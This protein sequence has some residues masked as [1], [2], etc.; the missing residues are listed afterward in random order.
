VTNDGATILKQ[1]EVEH[2]AAKVLVELAELQ[3]S[4]VGDGTTSV[5]ILAAE[6]L[7][8]ANELVRNRIHPT[9]IMSGY[10]MAVKEAVK[11]IK[12]HLTVS[13]D[14]ME[15]EYLVNA[16]RTSMSSKILGSQNAELFAAMAVDAVTSVRKETPE[17]TKYPISNIHIIKSHGKSAAES[18]LV[19]GLALPQA[20]VSQQMPKTITG[21]KIALLDFN[22]Q[23]HR[24]QLGVQV[25]V[26]DPAQLEAIRQREADITKETIARICAAGAN[27]IFT[28]KAIDDLCQKYLVE[29][30]VLA[31]RRASKR[32]LQRI[33]SATG[34]TLLA[35]LADLEGGE[36]L[37]PASLGSAEEV[38]EERV[39]DNDVVYVR[40]PKHT[41]AVSI[42]LRGAN[43]FLLDEMDRSLHDVLCV[44]QRVLESKSVVA[45]GGAVEAALSMYLE[46]FATSLATKEQ[47]AIREFAEALLAIPRTL[48]VNAA[49]DA[50]ELVAK[51]CAFHTAAQAQPEKSDLRFMGLDLINGKTVNNLQ[52]GVVEPAMSKV[53]SLKF[54]TE[55]AIT[56]LRIDD[57]IKSAFFFLRLI[58]ECACAA[59]PSFLL[60]SP[61]PLHTRTH[62]Q[63]THA[64]HAT[65]QIATSP[66][67]SSQ[68]SPRLRPSR[69]YRP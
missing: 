41:K 59:P 44:V 6:L 20:R 12:S 14:K 49:K 52:V 8:R 47:L 37:D 68:Q 13:T 34:G 42:L 39:G 56:I 53:K 7:R 46:S 35:N 26:T 19:R 24:M 1:L 58:C 15:R 2:P 32:D 33:A 30:G 10:R 4:E 65:S 18:T 64:A 23:R 51:L 67:P 3:D 60:P 38:A 36:T 28:T 9:T 57:F 62:A 25:L 21:A 40:G 5:V 63:A 27:V 66:P 55:A 43:D 48:S 31:V 61:P 45:G 69:V 54:A 50:T 29:R 11:Y 16:A 22:L 17:G